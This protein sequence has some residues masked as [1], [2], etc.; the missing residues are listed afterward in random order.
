MT[1][2]T[3][4]IVV[5]DH[6]MVAYGLK[7]ILEETKRIEVV[8]MA[9]SGD[10]AVRKFMQLE[11]DVV[12]MDIEMP[13]M[14]G[15]EATREIIA[16]A[17]GAKVLALTQF[18]HE[19]IETVV[20]AGALGYMRKARAGPDLIRAIDTVATGRMSFPRVQ[21]SSL[22]L[23]CSRVA[24][25]DPRIQMATLSEAERRAL[26]LT[27][28]GFSAQQIAKKMFV[29]VGSV[30]NYRW[31]IRG[32]LRLSSRPEMVDFALRAGLLWEDDDL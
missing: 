10:E 1:G 11:S 28:K 17:P 31:R 14:S 19:E 32:K 21:T 6:E 23:E 29:A 5:D 15:I 13:G 2:D 18:G 27:A 16:R 3:T 7:L 30:Y 24:R 20:D 25:S 26:K 9:T 22:L 12:V 8:G 4:V